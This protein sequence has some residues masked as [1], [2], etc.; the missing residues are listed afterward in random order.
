MKNEEKS[1]VVNIMGQIWGKFVRKIYVIVHKIYIFI[2]YF[3]G[4]IDN[5]LVISYERC[6][7]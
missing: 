5:Y 6:A 1:G 7:K 2:L 3:C 4:Q